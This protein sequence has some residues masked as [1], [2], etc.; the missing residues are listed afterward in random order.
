MKYEGSYT[1]HKYYPNTTTTITH[2]NTP[3]TTTTTTTTGTVLV[4]IE[5]WT[6]LVVNGMVAFV[7][8]L[9]LGEWC[10]VV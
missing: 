6:G 9:A 3:T 5:N 8:P 7:L 1:T 10:S 2:T 4:T